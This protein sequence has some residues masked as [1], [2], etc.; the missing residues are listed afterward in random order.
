MRA[1]RGR[2]LAERTQAAC[3][4][5]TEAVKEAEE[6]LAAQ[7]ATRRRV[8]REL[9]LVLAG[10]GATAIGATLLVAAVRQIT[11]V[12]ETQIQ[13]G[14]TLVGFA[15]AFELVMLCWSAA[16]RGATGVALAGVVGSF[17]YNV[18]MSLGAGALV[19]PLVIEDGQLLHRGLQA[20]LWL[21]RPLWRTSS[22]AIPRSSTAC[23]LPR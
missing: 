6:E 5:R 17:A 9:G 20:N 7:P 15:T 2:D 21:D 16:R 14:L 23:R 18:T 10:I 12:E 13:L 8:G 3:P 19:R 4:R 11:G 1:L 22:L